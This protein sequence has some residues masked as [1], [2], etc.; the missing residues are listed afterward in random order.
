MRK[1]RETAAQDSLHKAINEVAKEKGLDAKA[2]T[3]TMEQAILMAAKRTFGVNRELEARF[4]EESGNVDLFQYMTVVEDVENPEREMT[5]EDAKDHNLDAQVGEELG[6]QIFYLPQDAKQAAKQDTEFGELLMLTSQRAGFGRIAAQAAKQVIIQ[7]VRDAE[8]EVL[9]NEYKSK[10]GEIITGHVRRFER[11]DS[12][13]V[14]LEGGREAV[15]PKREQ[16]PRENYR[17][18]DR[19]DAILK[20]IDKDARGPQL[21]LS[22]ADVQLLV[23]LFER[24]VT[25]IFEGIVK[26]V[27]AAREPGARSKIAVSSRDND[28]DPVG[29]CVGMKGSRVQAV[30]QELRG[31]KIDIVPWDRDPARF[32]CNAI[33]PAEV[34]RVV[35]DEANHAMELVVPDEKLSLAIGRRGQN[36]RLAQQLCGWKLEIIGE[37]KFRQMEEAAL[38]EL[39]QLAGVDESGVRA[40]YRA[41]F[42]SLEE[43]VEAGDQELSSIAEIVKSV[44]PGVLRERAEN[45]M[46]KLRSERVREFAAKDEAISNRDKLLLLTGVGTRTAAALEAAGYRS[47]L[48]IEREAD[49]DKISLKAGIAAK[50][51]AAVRDSAIELV[52]KYR[53]QLE[54]VL[55]V[56]APAPATGDGP[57][58]EPAKSVGD[59]E[60]A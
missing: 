28:V 13:I 53:S 8:R 4:N 11:G 23:K 44:Q 39:A 30:V 27:A 16:T 57:P 1:T 26:I 51:A 32:V 50:R 2:L 48:E 29:A 54:R 52:S 58:H 55:A 35:I 33:A 10:R 22:R 59:R 38:G 31:E 47:P 34:T 25:E 43:I 40:L 45:G 17:P 19:I 12:I 60:T 9:F 3:E 46:E 37:S 7:R 6:F 49:A 20:E 24:E 56:S 41:G 42:R 15:L 36:V 14:D 21:V 5:V 18:G